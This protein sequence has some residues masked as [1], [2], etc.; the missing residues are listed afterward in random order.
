MNVEELIAKLRAENEWLQI[1][2][3]NRDADLRDIKQ[4]H[5]R[6]AKE[7]RT[8]EAERALLLAVLKAAREHH[9]YCWG[10]LEPYPD[11]PARDRPL[12]EHEEW[13]KKD[14]ARRAGCSLGPPLSDCEGIETP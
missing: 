6:I 12:E 4:A 10:D 9:A 7:L 8:V 13:S 14:D 1:K 5:E 3:A 2:L 11:I